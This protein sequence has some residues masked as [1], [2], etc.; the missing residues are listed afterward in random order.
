MSI[1][2]R[3]RR[4][5]EF[6]KVN[7]GEVNGIFYISLGK[8]NAK[9]EVKLFQGSKDLERDILNLCNKFRKKAKNYPLWIKIDIV[10]GTE[11]VFYD[12][13]RIEMETCRRNYIEYGIVLDEMWNLSFLPEVIN[14]NAFIKPNE[15]GKKHNLSEKNINSYLL[16]Y[17]T[18][19]RAFKHELYS[20]KR[21]RKFFTKSFI[22]DDEEVFE[23]EESGYKK[24]LRKVDNLSDEINKLIETST[25]YLKNEI[26]SNGKYI[27]GYFPHF[28]KEIGFYNNLRH[29]SSTYAM[30]EGL[31]YTKQDIKIAAKPIQYLIDNYL[32]I[33]DGR[34]YI[35]DDTKQ[36]NEIKLGQSSA[37]IFAVCEYLK[38]EENSQFL[39]AAQIVAEGLL[40]MIDLNNGDTTHVL[41]YPD[42]TVKEK[43]RIIYYDGEAALAL[44]RLYQ[45]DNNEKWLNLV[46]VMFEKFIAKDYWK[47]HDHWLGYCTNEL[48][49]ISP[50][51]RYFELGIKN[52][53]G[54]LDYIYHRETTFPTF[55]EMMMATYHLVQK[56]KALG[57]DDLIKENIDEE[58][59]L[60]T[61]HKRAEYQR[62]GYF[63]PEIAMYFKNPKRI[64]NS[65][66]IKHHGYRVR[67]DDVEHY[68]SG[69]VQYQKVFKN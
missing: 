68:L 69:Y 20:G 14:A 45:R 19:K 38:Y 43:H 47:Y 52:V 28:D 1:E 34:G 7:Y 36:V 6:V 61:I 58:K 46:K 31:N 15:F 26:Q 53:S 35:F 63:Y 21:V 65:F 56:A 55:L 40:S 4:L 9:A 54:H 12:D 32:Y 18:Q 10:T 39:K 64:L 41:N 2:N 3:V 67:I 29:S 33:K 22:L 60:N 50:D 37:F 59:F 17:T 62:V 51:E 42:L 49:Q 5:V 24:G 13:L 16:R 8:E 57:M 66:F 48:V 27:Y 11:D 44:L 25:N 23:L 30:I